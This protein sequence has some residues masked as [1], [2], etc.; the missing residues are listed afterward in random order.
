M[1][2][3][4]GRGG[5]HLAGPQMYPLHHADAILNQANPVQN[6]WYNVLPTSFNTRVIGI[7]VNIIGAAE[8][9][10]V[11]LTIDGNVY[12][13]SQAQNVATEY[14]WVWLPRSTGTLLVAMTPIATAY[15]SFMCEGHS[16]N[17]D[18]RKTSAGASTALQCCV[19]HA[20]RS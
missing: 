8:T 15:H 18:V 6:Q 4:K 20:V 13:G 14:E 7:S 5:R 16:I 19:S 3:Q 12:T 1:G 11:R 9:I 17:V 10:E 2:S